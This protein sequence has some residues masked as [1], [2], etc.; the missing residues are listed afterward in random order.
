ME[1]GKKTPT[2]TKPIILPPTIIPTISPIPEPTKPVKPT[3]EPTEPVKLTPEPT[4]PIKQTP[5]PTEPGKPTPKPTK[6]SQIN[7]IDIRPLIDIYN[8]YMLYIYDIYN[9]LIDLINNS[10]Y[11]CTNL[12][13]LEIMR[14][15]PLYLENTVV[16]HTEKVYIFA[17]L[18]DER[19]K[20]AAQ[21]TN[22]FLDKILDTKLCH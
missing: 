19:M 4:E 5:K 6:P 14:F 3:P 11:G 17:N 10:K 8:N 16:M 2:P 1:P 15:E 9:G 7:T 21:L 18:L 22:E 12:G 20:L 13:K